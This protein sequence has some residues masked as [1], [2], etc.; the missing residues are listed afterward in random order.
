M[1]LS[2]ILILMLLVFSACTNTTDT[3]PTTSQANNTTENTQVIKPIDRASLTQEINKVENELYNSKSFSFNAQKANAVV[4]AYS[5]FTSAYPQDAKTP[6]YLFKSAEIYRSLKQYQK[7][8]T[9]YQTIC[10]KYPDFEKKPHSLF[11][12]GFSYENDLK[13]LDEAKKAYQTFLDKHPSHELA[14]DVTFS[15]SNLGRAPE[16]IIKEFE[17]NKKK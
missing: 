2:H 4:A 16:D 8:V 13:N 6:E 15:L 11:L 14:K 5:Q 9:T 10:D 1:K 3:T 17:K 12:M 7:A